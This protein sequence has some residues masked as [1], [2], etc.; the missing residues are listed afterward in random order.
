MEFEFFSLLLS[1]SPALSISPYSLS[2]HPSM[3]P[4][5]HP[6]IGQSICLSFCLSTYGQ[7]SFARPGISNFIANYPLFFF[8]IFFSLSVNM[9]HT[10]K[11]IIFEKKCSN[12]CINPIH[13]VCGCKF[14]YS[15]AQQANSH[16]SDT[17]Q[18]LLPALP[19]LLWRCNDL[20][21]YSPHYP[22]GAQPHMTV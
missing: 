16:D 3:H 17:G 21:A 2:I 18:G 10:Y 4:C 13:A 9:E 6:S 7:R 14:I 15:R 20:A 1:C 5:M 11:C 22:Y 8:S 19:A 12:M